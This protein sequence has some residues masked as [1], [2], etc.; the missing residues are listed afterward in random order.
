MINRYITVLMVV[1]AATGVEAQTFDA[2]LKAALAE[3]TVETYVIHADEQQADDHD[4]VRHRQEPGC[5]HP[6]PAVTRPVVA[7]PTP[8]LPSLAPRG[9]HPIRAPD[10]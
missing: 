5:P 6:H 8:T 2:A 3:L 1:L 4:V 7:S 10:R 9:Y